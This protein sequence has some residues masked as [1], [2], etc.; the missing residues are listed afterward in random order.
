MQSQSA[1]TVE[2]K[3]RRHRNLNEMTTIKLGSKG[4]DVKA[5]QSRLN[6]VADG[7]FGPITDEAVRAF[8]KAN[9][10]AVDGIAGEKTWGKLIW[11][12]SHDRN[13]SEIIIHCSATPE[14]KDY[15]VEQIR[16]WHTLP[17]PKGNG[18]SDIGYHYIIYRDG[19]IHNGRPVFQVGAHCAGH[20]TQSI[21]IC[22]I[23]GCASDG[24][25]PKDTRTPA[26]KRAMVELLNQLRRKYPH[27]KIY[28]HRDFSNKDCPS[29]DA[30]T[31]YA[32]I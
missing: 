3:R 1:A 10:L 27:A 4:P 31:E 6:L 17:K 8:Q 9:G 19:S 12:S 15:T 18:W 30:K 5:L 22:Y 24:K 29:F 16:Q 7:I 26:Q 25:T 21:S 11:S 20:N 23:G 32:K 13:I 2:K 14:G 28:G